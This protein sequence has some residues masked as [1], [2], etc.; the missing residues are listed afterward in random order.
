MP[1][2]NVILLSLPLSILVPDLYNPIGSL[3]HLHMSFHMGPT[4]QCNLFMISTLW[5]YGWSS[6]WVWQVTCEGCMMC[7]FWIAMQSIHD[8]HIMLV[9]FVELMNVASHIWGAWCA[10]IHDT[11]L[12]F[13]SS[14]MYL[15][16]A[17]IFMIHVNNNLWFS[18]QNLSI[19]PTD[20]SFHFRSWSSAFSGSSS[21]YHDHLLC[22]QNSDACVGGCES[23]WV[24]G[25][26]L[27]IFSHERKLQQMIHSSS[28]DGQH[29]TSHGSQAHFQTTMIIC[30]VVRIQMNVL[31][32]DKAQHIQMCQWFPRQV[33]N[34]SVITTKTN[35]T[36]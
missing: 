1:L 13:S 20:K 24:V 8:I 31:S 4:L 26:E 11:T 2:H 14:A 21:D 30:F 17:P 22:G 23:W 35:I 27:V 12:W 3:S 19:S 29:H 7:T 33:N 5:L 9:L 16:A 10:P 36:Q 32:Q 6:S 34:L 15:R 25:K 18:K 28:H